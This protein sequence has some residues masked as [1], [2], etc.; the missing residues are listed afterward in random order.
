[1]VQAKAMRSMYAQYCA[2]DKR[3]AYKDVLNVV[4]LEAW[5]QAYGGYLTDQ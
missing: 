5:L 1:L 3:V 2:G 4:T